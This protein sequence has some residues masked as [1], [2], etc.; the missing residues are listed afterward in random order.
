MVAR[1]GGGAY[2]RQFLILW[3]F[4]AHGLLTCVE[5]FDA[6]REEEALARFDEIVDPSASPLGNVA[7]AIKLP[8]PGRCR[9]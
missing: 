9:A 5:W 7:T 2:E 3:V 4:G 6:D 8:Q 1:A